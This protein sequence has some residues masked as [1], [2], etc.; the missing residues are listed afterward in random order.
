MSEAAGPLQAIREALLIR[1]LRQRD[2]KAFE[3]VVV[4]YRDKVF[5]LV[6]RMVGN[7][8]EA[9]DL[10][11]EVFITVLKSIHT[12]RGDSRFSTWLYRI[13]SNHTKN[14]MKYLHRRAYKATGELDEA[15]ENAMTRGDAQAKGR[16]Q[17]PETHMAGRQIDRVVQ[18]AIAQLDEDHREIIVLRDM[19][20]L[21]YE[22]IVEI[23]GLAEGTVK[24]RLHRARTA[25]KEHV[26]KRLG[27]G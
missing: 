20:E 3:E 2:E 17:T 15:A 13:A 23:T 6:L 14:R 11:Q 26:Q 24:S 12:F 21:S 7:R 22:E 8:E 27:E 4:L 18:D 25:L 16:E 9:D 5:G 10:A 19:E 1:R